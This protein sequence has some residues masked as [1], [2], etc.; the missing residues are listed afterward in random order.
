MLNEYFVEMIL[1]CLEADRVNS[2]L[3]IGQEAMKMYPDDEAIF[4]VYAAAW[5]EAG[6]LEN[7]LE[8][9][10]KAAKLSNKQSVY[11]D[12]IKRVKESIEKK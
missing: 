9:Y 11:D 10:E 6:N 8:Y 1:E 12:D 7:S 4:S 2:A 3:C 5:E